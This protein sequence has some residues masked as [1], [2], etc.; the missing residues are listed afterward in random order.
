MTPDTN[1]EWKTVYSGT[2]SVSHSTSSGKAPPIILDGMFEGEPNL[3]GF[4]IAR[5]TTIQLTAI[6]T[7]ATITSAPNFTDE[8]SPTLTYSNKAGS[9]VDSLQACISFDGSTVNIPYRDISETGTSYTFEFTDSERQTLRNATLD[10]SDTKTVYFVIKTVLNGKTYHTQMAKTLTIT[11][12]NPGLSVFMLDTNPT[13]SALTGDSLAYVIQGYS[14]MSY[15]MS[16]YGAKGAEIVGYSAV[17]GGTTLDTETGAFTAPEV[18]TFTFTATDSRGLS[19][20]QEITLNLIE[21]A[22]PTCSQEATIEMD[23]ETTATVKLV[24]QGEWS[25][26]HFGAVHNTLWVEYSYQSDNGEWSEWTGAEYITDDS[27]YK[28]TFTIEGLDYKKQHTFKSRARD[29]L[30]STETAEYTVK[31]IPV[32]EWDDNDFQFNVPVAIKGNL[33]VE[34][35]INVSGGG[36]TGPVDYVIEQGTA[37]MGTNGT[38]YWEKWKNGK[39]TC[40]GVRNY[41][42]MGVSTAWGDLYRSAIFTQDLPSGLFTEAPAVINI[43]F[44][45]GGMSAWVVKHEQTAP[46]A[47]TTGSFM[48]VRAASATLS[49][50]Y[51]DFN[52]I[53]RWK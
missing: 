7:G 30:D 43:D 46:G 22:K 24:V 15:E 6:P 31:L 45:H 48:V 21:Y 40:Y 34:G 37:A 18:G 20:T 42:N 4:Y 52:L 49:Q 26:R 39:A 5:G 36:D 16:A 3:I 13:T 35:T 17:N 19:A 11:N 32:F 23:G 12:A 53:G 9:S 10:G 25:S 33:T 2:Y 8:D 29:S 41:G 47:N 50:V 28:I 14:T 38:W 27:D 51:L 44:S 1:G